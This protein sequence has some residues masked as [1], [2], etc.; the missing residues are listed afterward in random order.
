[1]ED[2]RRARSRRRR[3]G[4]SLTDVLLEAGL[5]AAGL[6]LVAVGNSARRTAIVF[7]DGGAHLLA[8]LAMAT[9]AWLLLHTA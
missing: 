4:P 3:G 8:T 9:G 2:C 5:T 1:M 6:A 7:D